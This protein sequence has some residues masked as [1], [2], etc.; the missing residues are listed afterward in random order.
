MLGVQFRERYI[1]ENYE[2]LDP[3]LNLLPQLARFSAEN[4]SALQEL[5]SGLLSDHAPLPKSSA[6]GEIRGTLEKLI[7]CTGPSG[8][9]LSSI[10]R[11][12]IRN[13]TDDLRL[14]MVAAAMMTSPASA[15]VDGGSLSDASALLQARGG[16]VSA[17]MG[18]NMVILLPSIET[19]EQSASVLSGILDV[20]DYTKPTMSWVVDFSAVDKIS[21]MT[22]GGITGYA[23]NLG[24]CGGMLY[25]CWL[26]E[27][28]FPPLTMGALIKQ[29]RLRKVGRYYFSAQ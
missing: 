25:A 28:L 14:R 21:I 24:A 6:A 20:Y 9:S 8:D 5:V 27:N 29:L 17:T 19:P 12:Q 7:A 3:V 18:N 26:R 15:P 1:E 16:V 22:L 13:A 10:Q 4:L 11:Q 23:L 2:S